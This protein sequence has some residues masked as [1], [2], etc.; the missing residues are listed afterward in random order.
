MYQSF[1]PLIRIVITVDVKIL[2]SCKQHG[3]LHK[4]ATYEWL[5]SPSA[6]WSAHVPDHCGSQFLNVHQR[7][8][9]RWIS[10]LHSGSQS[11]GPTSRQESGEDERGG[12]GVEFTRS[13]KATDVDVG[14]IRM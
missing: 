13:T 9:V 7:L 6:L 5:A 2:R 10:V 3:E 11:D 4:H 14:F 1:L 12:G 8:I